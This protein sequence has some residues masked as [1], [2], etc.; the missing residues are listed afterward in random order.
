M[1]DATEG[2]T[3]FW[4]YQ[5]PAGSCA[6]AALQIELSL[7]KQRRLQSPISAFISPGPAI[8]RRTRQLCDGLLKGKSA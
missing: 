3:P 2:R 6:R 8:I 1:L 4:L 7:L 5:I